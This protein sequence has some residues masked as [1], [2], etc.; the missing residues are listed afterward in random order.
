MS[1][2]GRWSLV[3]RC[4]VGKL[5]HHDRRD[6]VITTWTLQSPQREDAVTRP[7]SLSPAAAVT[8]NSPRF[9]RRVAESLSPNPQ[10]PKKPRRDGLLSAT[11]RRR[12]RVNRP[13]YVAAVYDTGSCESRRALAR[14][15]QSGHVTEAV[16]GAC[17]ERSET[18]AAAPV[19][20]SRHRGSQTRQRPGSALITARP[21]RAAM[22]RAGGTLREQ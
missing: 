9:A 16:Y 5:P 12:P 17:S 11:S 20:G 7:T 3:K 4:N 13:N 2:R 15:S 19:H 14:A 8:Q 1:L 18:T 21:E 10:R 22:R 6:D